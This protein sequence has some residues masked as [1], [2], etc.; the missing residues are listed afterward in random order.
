MLFKNFDKF[1]SALHFS[2]LNLLLFSCRKSLRFF[3]AHILTLCVFSQKCAWKTQNA[4][5]KLSLMWC[6][7][8]MQKLKPSSHC[9]G[10]VPNQRASNQQKY[11]QQDNRQNYGK[12]NI[13]GCFVMTHASSSYIII[14]PIHRFHPYCTCVICV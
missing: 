13:L 9:P 6:F 1:S 11:T 8:H 2:S 3:S 12:V 7:Y 4:D 5:Q 14:M 10:K